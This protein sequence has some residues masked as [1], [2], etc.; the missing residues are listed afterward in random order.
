MGDLAGSL[1]VDSRGARVFVTGCTGFV[2]AW[3]CDE[4]VRQGASVT[5]LV[6]PS[7][8]IA[9]YQQLGLSQRITEASGDIN[10]AAL[11]GQILTGQPF[12]FIFHL[13]ARAI[14]SDANASPAET[15]EV[16]IRGTWNLLE[17]VRTC[18]PAA[19][20]IVA[21]NDKVYG[22]QADLPYTE[23]SPFAATHPYDVSKACADLLAASYAHSLGLRVAVVRCGNI[24]GGGDLNVSR[25]V[26]GTIRAALSGERPFIRSDGTLTRDYIHIRDVVHAY[27]A[28]AKALDNDL[29]VGQ[30]FNFGNRRPVAVLELVDRIL[31][32]VGRPDLSPVIADQASGEIQHQWLD[33]SKAERELGWRPTVG[34]DEGLC[35]AV[36]WYRAFAATDTGARWI[37]QRE[38]APT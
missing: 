26:P 24:Y 15:F 33:S 11:L 31:R 35:E 32:C 28:V 12:D 27:L 23:S 3:L 10:D 6:W 34:L 16:N 19:H 21:T 8:S 4:L 29:C 25:L 9:A 1:M 20:L 22:D 38:A 36:D 30:A 17:T 14:V 7:V 2:G 37:G 5:G 13:A 18:Q